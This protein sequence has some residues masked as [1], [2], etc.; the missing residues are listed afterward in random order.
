[1]AKISVTK[2]DR[3]FLSD[4]GTSRTCLDG[5]LTTNGV[6][7]DGTPRYWAPEV[8]DGAD[9]N[10]ASDVW[11]LGCVFLEMTTILFGYTHYDLLTFFSKNGTENYTRISLNE[12]A[13]RLWIKY[14]GDTNPGSDVGVLEW[15]LLMLQ[16]GQAN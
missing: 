3:V 8:E 15:T 6:P 1:M 9:R 4:F 5:R 7:R 2:D 10:T 12:E 14:L 13:I 11:S 16:Y